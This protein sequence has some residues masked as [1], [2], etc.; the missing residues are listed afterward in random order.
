MMAKKATMEL[1]TIWRDRGIRKE[2]KMKLVEALIGPD[3]KYGAE[4]WKDDVRRLEAAE[5]W[6]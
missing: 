2:L 4:G 6:C 1:D 5:M 3:I